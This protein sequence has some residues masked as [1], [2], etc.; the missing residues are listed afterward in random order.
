MDETH[1]NHSGHNKSSSFRW[2][3]VG[4]WGAIGIISYFLLTEHRAHLNNF[5]PYAL[6]L[7]L[8][9]MHMFMHGGHG[10]HGNHNGNEEQKP[11][12]QQRG[13]H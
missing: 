6:L 1:T 3:K 4:L 2:Y 7:A 9:F 10:G 5:L 13:H 8:P 12:T 11:K